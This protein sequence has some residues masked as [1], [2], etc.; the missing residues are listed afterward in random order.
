M[1]LIDRRELL[2]KVRWFEGVEYCIWKFMGANG[3]H[4]TVHGG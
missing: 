1:E 3:Q 4:P 2:A